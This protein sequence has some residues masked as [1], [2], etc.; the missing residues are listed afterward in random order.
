MSSPSPAV[1]RGVDGKR[2]KKPV[3]LDFYTLFDDNRQPIGFAVR[4]GF[5]VNHIITGLTRRD[6]NVGGIE[7]KRLSRP[8]VVTFIKDLLAK[9]LP[10]GSPLTKAWVVCDT[11]DALVNGTERWQRWDAYARAVGRVLENAQGNGKG[12]IFDSYIF[13]VTHEE[14]YLCADEVGRLLTGALDSEAFDRRMRGIEVIE[15]DAE[16]DDLRAAVTF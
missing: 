11:S 7:I 16:E 6:Q 8:A 10:T 5:L 13:T 12:S 15:L 1:K 4:N 9:P 2:K 14:H 3:I